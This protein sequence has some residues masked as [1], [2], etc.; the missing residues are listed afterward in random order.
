MGAGG[1]LFCTFHGLLQWPP[2]LPVT[3][4]SCH[5]RGQEFVAPACQL[6]LTAQYFL[7]N[8]KNNNNNN[9]AQRVGAFPGEKRTSTKRLKTIQFSRT[10]RKRKWYFHFFELIRIEKENKNI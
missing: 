7:P 2:S 1:E 6:L 3:N 8:K 9:K 5:C 10:M 4:I